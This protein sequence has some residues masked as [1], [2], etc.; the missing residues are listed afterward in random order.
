MIRTLLLLGATGDLA[1][2]FLLPAVEAL[3]AA[4]RL[5]AGFRV[6]AAGRRELEDPSRLATSLEGAP[7]A[8]YLALPPAVFGTA[9]QTL[10]EV[11]LPGGSRVVVEKPFGQDLESAETL[12]ALLRRTGIDAYRVDHLL[13]METTRRLVALRREGTLLEQLWSSE[14]VDQVE[15]L[16]EET[17]A[18][19][20][21]AG[22]YDHAGALVDVL[23]SHMLQLLALVA[24]EP[25]TD[26]DDL[27]ARKLDVLRSVRLG[28]E[29]RRARYTAGRLADGREVPSYAEEEGVDPA[30]GTET[31][32]E[33][34][35]ELDHPRWRGTRFVLRAGKALP[36]R[37]KLALLRF[38]SGGGLEIG[39][40]GPEDIVLRVPVMGET[41]ELRSPERGDGLPAYA[42]VLLDVLGGT[43]ALSVGGSETE[44]AWRVV[45]PVLAA[46]RSGEVALEEYVAGSQPE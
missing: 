40:D 33:V 41:L 44:Q 1:R 7:V 5:P 19:E 31:F 8:A 20:G 45:A 37:R 4:G 46:W 2:R 34:T 29:S 32:A 14:H 26:D 21:R 6:V 17:L 39:I 38:R 18:L 27:H 43:T 16:W 35:L 42:N 13:G 36:R 15:I 25:P 12:N 30:R 11:G 22:Y 23:Q 24:M 28:R 10:A 9:I 3:D